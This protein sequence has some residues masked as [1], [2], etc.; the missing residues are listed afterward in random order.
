MRTFVRTQQL[1][2]AIG[3]AGELG[4]RVTSSD[5]ELIGIAGDRARVTDSLE[6]R[7][8][9][10]AEADE[11]FERAKLVVEPGPGRLDLAEPSDG[12]GGLRALAR[13]LGGGAGNVERRLRIEAPMGCAVT[14]VGVSGDLTSIGLRG[15]QAYRTVSGDLVLDAIGGDV[16]IRGVSGDLSLRAELPLRA[17]EINT[18]S[19]DVSAIAPEV[20]Q[21]RIVTVSGDVDVECLLADGPA[22]RVETVSGDLS[23]GVPA[24][25]TMEVRGL[26]SDVDVRLPH[27]VEG[28]RDR[29][30]Y[31]V[32]SGG[33]AV[34]FSS[35]SGDVEV[36]PPRRIDRT[37]T[38]PTPP[39]PATPPTPPTPPAHSTPPAT[40]AGTG[41][42][43]ELEVLRALERGEI[44]VDEA[45]RRLLGRGGTD[46]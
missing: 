1:E 8:S 35:M 14:Y 37:P 31:V 20:G 5:V 12:P 24:G 4:I 13:L 10:D 33:P 40:A 11:V 19:G 38:P 7:A 45:A 28:S 3:G 26:S 23:L 22:H 27:R 44:D 36:R 43:A 30:R 21:L 2:H 17:L 16:R 32:G 34:L 46:V 15:T 29:R 9:S 39:T 6:I 25:L 42:A 18:V 41:E